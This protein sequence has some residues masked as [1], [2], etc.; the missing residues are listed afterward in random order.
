MALGLYPA[1]VVPPLVLAGADLNPHGPQHVHGHVQVR[2]GG[3]GWSFVPDPDPLVEKCSAQQQC[4]DELRGAR[5][6]QGDL[7]TTHSTGATDGEGQGTP[8]TVVDVRTQC[9]QRVQQFVD[10]ALTSPGV[11]VEGDLARSEEHTSELQSRGHLVC[12]LLREKNK[13]K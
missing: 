4:R 6:V 13:N 2:L 5:G 8:A 9:T 1:S 10:G 12:R 7:A 11:T 3:H